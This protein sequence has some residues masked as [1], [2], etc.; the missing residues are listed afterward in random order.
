MRAIIQRVKEAKVEVDGEA[1]G[2]I[3]KGILVF[4]GIG[5][6]DTD[7]DIEYMVNK[8][9]GLRIFPDGNNE[10]AI[11]VTEIGGD[12]MVVSQFTLFGDLRKGKRPSFTDAMPPAHAKEVFERLLGAFKQADIA[13]KTG[14][15]QAMM[16][17]SLVN[18]G[19][20][21]VLLDSAKVF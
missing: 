13:V 18:D 19:P 6:S 12:I 20:Y 16:D 10:T 5:K 9:P 2:S 11:S 4:V 7:K 8:I 14:V 21:T 1:V 3:G 15:F 17:I